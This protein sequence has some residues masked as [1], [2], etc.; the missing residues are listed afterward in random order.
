MKKSDRILALRKA[1]EAMVR[2]DFAP[3]IPIGDDDIGQLGKSLKKLSSSLQKQFDKNQSLYRIM[4]ESN[5][6]LRLIDVLNHIYES[7]Q[8]YE[9]VCST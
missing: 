2:G 3:S 9:S 1:A 6:N 5:L 4:V 7:F 8:E